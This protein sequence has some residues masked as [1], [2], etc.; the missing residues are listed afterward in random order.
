MLFVVGMKDELVPPAHCKRLHD[1]A[2]RSAY[3][4]LEVFPLSGH[5]DCCGAS[6]Y[7]TRI[8]GFMRT[9][10]GHQKGVA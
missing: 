7:A 5:N 4:Q 8:A 1:A 10:A 2:R 9:A 6:G 3:R